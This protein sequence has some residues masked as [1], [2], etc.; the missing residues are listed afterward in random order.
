VVLGAEAVL[1][2]SDLTGDGNCTDP[3]ASLLGPANRHTRLISFGTMTGRLG[4]AAT[5]RAWSSSGREAQKV[6]HLLTTAFGTW[7]K[8]SALQQLRQLRETR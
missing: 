4:F 5:D 7:R 6:E 1:S 2:L 8:V 3:F